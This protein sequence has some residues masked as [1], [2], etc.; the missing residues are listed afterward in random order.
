MLTTILTTTRLLNSCHRNHYIL[1]SLYHILNLAPC[2]MRKGAILP[3]IRNKAD[4]GLEVKAIEEK[5][6]FEQ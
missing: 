2:S 6:H 4:R 1:V 5:A 3:L